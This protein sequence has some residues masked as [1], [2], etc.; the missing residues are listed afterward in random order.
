MYIQFELT[1]EQEKKIKQKCY[2]FC[3]KIITDEYLEE[4]FNEGING[5]VKTMILQIIQIQEFKEKI[6][7]KIHQLMDEKFFFE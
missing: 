3:N 7:K 6:F 4:K 5:Y 2:D 1:Q